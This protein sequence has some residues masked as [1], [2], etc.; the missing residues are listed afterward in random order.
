MTTTISIENISKWNLE[1]GRSYAKTGWIKKGASWINSGEKEDWETRTD[2]HSRKGSSGVIVYSV[3]GLNTSIAIAWRAPSNVL[4]LIV[5]EEEIDED[6]LEGLYDNM[7]SIIEYE[8]EQNRC[9]KDFTESSSQ[10]CQATSMFVVINGTI[11]GDSYHPHTKITVSPRD[12]LNKFIPKLVS[13]RPAY[14]I[15]DAIDTISA[16][17]K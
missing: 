8:N 15:N 16:L 3:E 10:S 1:W 2:S 13:P 9:V 12:T 4:A 11:E 17:S 14:S 7:T 5:I 6:Q